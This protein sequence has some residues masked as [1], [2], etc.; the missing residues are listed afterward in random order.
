[1]NMSFQ[2]S[3]IKNFKRYLI[4]DEKTTNTI[5]K[6]IRDVLKFLKF[7]SNKTCV[8]K[9]DVV[10]FKQELLLE[11][12][13]TSVNSMLIAVNQFLT[14]KGYAENKV[15]LLKSQRR[16]IADKNNELTREEYQRLLECSIIDERLHV[17]LQTLCSTGIRVSEHKYFTVES[18]MQS[19]IHIYNKGKE[20]TIF[21]S[22]ELRCI[23]LNY[24]KKHQIEKGPIF[25]TKNGNP[26]NRSN[27]WRMMKNLC[28]N[29]KVKKA[30]VFPHNLRHLFAI[31]YYNLQKNIV[32][33][34][35]LLGHSSI[36]TTRI[37]TMTSGWE[38]EQD[39]SLLNLVN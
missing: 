9:E 7:T 18:L 35:D 23:L 26:L 16:I 31:T 38:Y 8:K 33:L 1:M 24:C 12:K 17:L 32:K 10:L 20:R 34:A 30:K 13:V 4:E 11:Y 19:S 25:I 3:D 37:Y 5:E 27:I 22:K 39:L 21:I 14:F 29:A 28:Q 36:E 6:Y 2:K 15:K